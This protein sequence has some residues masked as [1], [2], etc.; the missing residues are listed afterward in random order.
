MKALNQIKEELEKYNKKQQ[1]LEDTQQQKMLAQKKAHEDKIDEY[2]RLAFLY[3]LAGIAI[4][5]IVGLIIGS[6]RS[7]NL[8]SSSSELFKSGVL[9][10]TVK[11]FAF[12]IGPLIGLI[13][14][15]TEYHND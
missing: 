5:A 10:P 8:D 2:S 4:G 15:Y 6:F 12:L 7:C 13:I 1:E 14:A 3:A 11:F 9:W